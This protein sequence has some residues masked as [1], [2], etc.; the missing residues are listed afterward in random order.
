MWF[1]LEAAAA[2]IK[3]YVTGN[4]SG[5]GVGQLSQVT[6]SGNN[7]AVAKLTPVNKLLILTLLIFRYLN[8]KLVNEIFEL[9]APSTIKHNAG[10]SDNNPSWYNK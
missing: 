6:A 4:V 3:A 9:T 8:I 2:L 1:K 7:G 10:T 5:L